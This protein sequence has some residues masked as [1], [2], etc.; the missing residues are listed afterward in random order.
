MGI[1][2]NKL[3]TMT[4]VHEIDVQTKRYDD[5]PIPILTVKEA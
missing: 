4:Q 1:E 3:G 5:D 2:T